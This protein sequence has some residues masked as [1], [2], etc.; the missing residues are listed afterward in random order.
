[1]I[2]EFCVDSKKRTLWAM[3]PTTA[4]YDDTSGAI[5]EQ[6]TA[7]GSVPARNKYSCG[8]QIVVQGLGV[9]CLNAPMIQGLFLVS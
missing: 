1:M 2:D 6:W 8:L 3:K 7:A 5:S 9:F 4:T